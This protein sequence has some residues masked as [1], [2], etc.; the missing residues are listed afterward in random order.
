M[1]P[2]A[3]VSSSFRGTCRFAIP[4]ILAAAATPVLAQIPDLGPQASLHGKQ[5]FPAS[6]PW[7][8]DISALPVDPNSATLIAT[9]GTTT[10]LHPDFGSGKNWTGVPFGIP[11]IVVA[12][13][14]PLVPT[15]F[16]YAD[17]SDPGPYPI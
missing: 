14:Q 10:N 4:L 11:Y 3:L 2:K 5:V 1:L 8:Q 9:L 13:T 7:N 15:H 12:G 16:T 17:Q 6:N